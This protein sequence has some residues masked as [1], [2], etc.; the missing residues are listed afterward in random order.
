MS[1]KRVLLWWACGAVAM[2]LIEIPICLRYGNL[3]I[4]VIILW[5]VWWAIGFL[6]LNKE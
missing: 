5:W 1:L 3:G 6:K 2:V 4:L